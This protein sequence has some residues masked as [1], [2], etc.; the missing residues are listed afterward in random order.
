[1]IVGNLNYSISFE[2]VLPKEILEEFKKC[3]ESGSWS[4]DIEN[5]GLF[6]F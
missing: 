3:E 4:G 5:K 6:N 1:L 2:N